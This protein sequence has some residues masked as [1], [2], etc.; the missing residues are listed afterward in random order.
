MTSS[1]DSGRGT[2]RAALAAFPNSSDTEIVL[3]SNVYVTSAL[4]Y[5]DANKK[6]KIR[7]ESTAVIVNTGSGDLALGIYDRNGAELSDF[8]VLYGGISIE[9]PSAT[10]GTTDI[11]VDGVHVYDSD[12]TGIL[13]DVDEN[14]GGNINVDFTDVVAEGNGSYTGYDM[15]GLPN[16]IL[17][18]DDHTGGTLDVNMNGCELN[19]NRRAGCKLWRKNGDLTVYVF[20]LVANGNGSLPPLPGEQL[21]GS[22]GLQCEQSGNGDS[23]V[24]VSIAQVHNN[25]EDGLEFEELGNGNQSVV[26]LYVDCEGCL[27][28]GIGVV[29]EDAG[30]LQC[31][32]Y[33]CHV[34]DHA[35]DEKDSGTVLVEL[36]DC[37][38]LDRN[39]DNV[40]AGDEGCMVRPGGTGNVTVN[41]DGCTL[42]DCGGRGFRM[43]NDTNGLDTTAVCNIKFDG[44]VIQNNIIDGIRAD[45]ATNQAASSI[46]IRAV[47]TNGDGMISQQE[48]T[49][50]V[51]NYL[52][53]GGQNLDDKGNWTLLNLA[54][55][56]QINN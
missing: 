11:S 18:F 17:V 34:A 38:L 23:Q 26:L 53:N 30:N 47:D 40:T 12:R 24:L 51:N 14:A 49:A 32:F 25:T 31:Q 42:S 7:A 50:S 2:L 29:E 4:T 10:A 45:I 15:S 46:D 3:K 21:E 16:G 54:T 13:I 33:G 1:A 56:P 19:D 20:D 55:D 8:A 44:C 41:V 6:L 27:D 37:H 36:N 28:E 48:T 39:S 52:N 22:D 43:R 9:L 5:P 35:G